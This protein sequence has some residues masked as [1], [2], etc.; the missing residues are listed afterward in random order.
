MMGSDGA[1]VLHVPDQFEGLCE[2]WRSRRGDRA[3]AGM[4]GGL[5]RVVDRVDFQVFADVLLRLFVES[6]IRDH[7][8]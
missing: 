8:T 3:G 2:R 5:G 1:R 6:Q 4:R 7:G